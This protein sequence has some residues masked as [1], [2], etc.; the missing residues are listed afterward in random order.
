M[1]LS[2]ASYIILTVFSSID[3]VLFQNDL[4]LYIFNNAK[5]SKERQKVSRDLTFS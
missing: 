4:A 3:R 1:Q 2:P 5:I